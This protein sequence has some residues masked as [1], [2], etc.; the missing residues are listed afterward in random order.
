[1]DGYASYYADSLSGNLT[2]SG[3]EYDPD[4]FSAAHRTLPFGTRVRVTRTDREVPPVCVTVN[5]RGP[6]RGRRRI[7]DLSRRAAE[8]LDMIGEGVV[9]VRVEVFPRGPALPGG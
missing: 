1:L 4:L 2:A 6:W 9:P 5:D 8:A 7:I 3:V